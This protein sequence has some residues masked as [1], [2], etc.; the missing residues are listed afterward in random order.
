M[1]LYD[2][3]NRRKRMHS[4]FDDFFPTEFFE[5]I[6]RMHPMKMVREPLVDVIDKGNYLELVA[7][8]PGIDKKD[9]KVNVEE[10]SVCIEA[11]KKLSLTEEDKK[12]GHFY[13]ER[14][15]SKFFRKIPLTIEVL[16][17]KSLAEMHD[18]ILK[19]K[20]EKLKPIPEKTKSFKVEVK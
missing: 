6:E 14:S 13:S 11:E 9:I 1:E 16:P 2:P 4:L 7:E 18:G 19:L 10:N 17:N 8:L 12:K 20:L 3:F 15:Y 5:P